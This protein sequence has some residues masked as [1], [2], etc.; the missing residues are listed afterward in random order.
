MS[1]MLRNPSMKRKKAETSKNSLAWCQSTATLRLRRCTSRDHSSPCVSVYAYRRAM[2]EFPV[3]DKD[4]LC[5]SGPQVDRSISSARHS[6]FGCSGDEGN[7][8]N[9]SVISIVIRE[10][11][12]QSEQVKSEQLCKNFNKGKSLFV[13]D[14]TLRPMPGISGQML[15]KTV[16]YDLKTLGRV[17]QTCCRDCRYLMPISWTRYYGQLVFR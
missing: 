13:C 8:K 15:Q 7:T 10:S 16:Q 12:C 9:G 11:K 4:E 6:K 2:L 3:L 5:D 17:L 14:M 1:K